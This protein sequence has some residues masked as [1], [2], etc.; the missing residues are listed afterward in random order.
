MRSTSSAVE[1]VGVSLNDTAAVIAVTGGS[2]NVNSP[3]Q[4]NLALTV[5]S[6]GTQFRYAAVTLNTAGSSYIGFSAEL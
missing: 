4:G 3:F 2:V 6:G 5:A 1:I